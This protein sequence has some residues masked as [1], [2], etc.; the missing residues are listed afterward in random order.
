MQRRFTITGAVY[1][2]QLFIFDELF[3]DESPGGMSQLL[4]ATGTLPKN[5]DEALGLV[6]LYLSLSYYGLKN[7][8]QFIVS[9]VDELPKEPVSF[10]DESINDIRD[11]V[12]APRVSP[13]ESGYEV[14]LFTTDLDRPRIH[15]WRVRTDP[16]GIRAVSDQ[17]IY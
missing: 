8:A 11:V 7:P 15:R 5:P 17:R 12:Y 1:A 2:G 6:E 16:T 14:D 13:A 4:Q 3:C 9:S 10:P